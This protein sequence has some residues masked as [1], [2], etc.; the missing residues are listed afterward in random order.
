M[1]F[2]ELTSILQAA[3]SPV[4]LISGVGLL[5]LSMTNRFGRVLD[6]ARQLGEFRR[7]APEQDQIRLQLQVDILIRRARLLRLTIG[8]ATLSV[9]MAAF[10]VITLFS[11]AFLH[12]QAVLLGA[13]LF[14]VCLV[15]LIISLLA[16]LQDINLSLAALKLEL[17]P[18]DDCAG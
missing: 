8:F 13:A 18:K 16:F 6:R 17:A 5:I 14:I 10:L 3:V 11:V 15:S 9:L 4:I 1:R 2:N 7:N 12:V